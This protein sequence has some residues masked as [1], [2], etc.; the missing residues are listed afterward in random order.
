M[1]PE[2]HQHIKR[3]FLAAVELSPSEQEA[4][5]GMACGT[6]EE[7]R[8]EIQSLLD[9]H[10]TQTLLESTAPA[11]AA[12]FSTA[13]TSTRPKETASDAADDADPARPAGTMIAGRYRLVAPLGRGGMG[14]VYR[15][16][17]TELAQTIALK[18]LSPRLKDYP[19]EIDF[20]RGEV[21][22]ARQITH[23]NVVRVFDI[24]TA[25]GETFITMEFVAGEELRSMVRR[26]GPLP[27][28][29]VH[30]I[31]RQLAA[32][33]A[34]AHEA[35]ILHRDLKPQNVMLDGAGNVRI[36]DF[37]IAAPLT[38]ERALA[39]LAG[40]PGFVA[41]ELLKGEKPSPKSDLY[42]W[43]LVI[44][45]VATGQ[46]PPAGKSP[47]AESDDALRRAGID[48]DL[49]TLVELCLQTD[50][51]RRPGSARELLA[52]LS[53]GD[54]LLDALQAGR[55]P[56]VEL[57]AATSSWQ[58]R[59][60]LIDGLFA[61]GLVL[62]LL[63]M[64]LGSRTLFL[65]RCGLVKSPVVLRD[66]AEHIIDK[67]SDQP[68][69]GP[70]QT[71]VA[72]DT[73]CLQYVRDHLV[74]KSAWQ[75]IAVGQ[76]PAVVFWYRQ[77][78]PHLP[79]PALLSDSD[80]DM[81][82]SPGTAIVRLDG[83]GKLLSLQVDQ[84]PRPADRSAPRPNRSQI[85][86]LA[87]LNDWELR[88]VEPRDVPPLFA[89]S[90]QEWEGPLNADSDKKLRVMAASLGDRLVYFD[91]MPPWQPTP[92][93]GPRP[94]NQSSIFV[95]CRAALWLFAIGLAAFL[96]WLHARQGSADWRGAWRVT[97]AVLVLAG[98]EWLCGSRHNF[99]LAEELT[100]AL[101]WLSAIIVCG[102][103]AGVT[104]LAVE[105]SA[106][107]WWPWSIIT[108]RR[109]LSGRLADRAIWADVLLGIVAGLGSVFLRQLCTLANQVLGI[110][111][112]GLNDFDPSQDLLDHFGLRT[113]LAVLVSALLYAA[114]DSLLL[115]TL[116][117]GV[118]RIVRSTELAGAFLVLLLAALAI[119][120]RGILSPI[121][122]LARG[123]LLSIATW[124]LLR[125]G[126]VASITALTTYY[127]VNNSPITLDTS[128]WF[129]PA[130]FFI[131]GLFAIALAVSWR[132][133]RRTAH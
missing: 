106:R 117:V 26:V 96:A 1:T 33:V 99:I 49:A 131:V 23:P 92:E 4:F 19:G 10:R 51:A 70:V 132:L 66:M 12:L 121:D 85:F 95:A 2:R 75:K 50:P 123:L 58:P 97:A 11:G 126:L 52:L 17:D 27:P 25:D 22:T 74:I 36:L 125:F 5:L 3:L 102:A 29:K 113:K 53:S 86:H 83:R 129:A 30:E 41:P 34:A 24:A 42:G 47:S 7:L 87:G 39:R 79:R 130:G 103:I 71:G 119:L 82:P 9:N 105:P 48:D 100:A 114:L 112:S 80:Q 44:Y 118:K 14:V 115:L 67:V 107:R 40:T 16:E 78:D 35:G 43:G 124:I 89:D 68:L 111:V 133:S 127:A 69:R 81:R 108:L 46:L 37:G 55:M 90:V 54:P 15:A 120:E 110:P 128:Q 109:L 57:L 45:Y 31:A 98:A 18:F 76:I 62:L 64:L 21:K 38:D 116:V 63:I 84:R 77:G 88:A 72:L 91:V 101:G 94:A 20:L 28:A 8:R 59:P 32:G 93:S 73:N 104:Y 61:G 60:R 122:W 13:L 6:D 56:S 65:S